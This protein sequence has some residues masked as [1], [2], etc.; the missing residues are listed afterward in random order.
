M[1]KFFMKKSMLLVFSL[2]LFAV[3]FFAVEG[4]KTGKPD[5][6][7]KGESYIEGLRIVHRKNGGGDWTLTASRA[8]LSENGEK[9]R[10]SDIRMNVENK[11]LVILADR[12]LYN[13]T[14]KNLFIEGKITASNDGYSITSENVE[15]NGNAGSL[16]TDGNVTVEGKKF[17]LEGKGMK[18]DN[19]AQKV[20]ILNDVK[21]VFNN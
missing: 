19:A 6:I 5:F 7:R 21:A 10:L 18:A 1:I 20:R 16:K 8:D 3:F 12:G 9:A 11:G 17:R 13:M 2:L 15:F 14:D 4:E